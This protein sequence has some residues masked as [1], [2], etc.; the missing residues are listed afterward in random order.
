LAAVA[1]VVIQLSLL[2]GVVVEEAVFSLTVHFQLFQVQY[3][4]IQSVVVGQQMPLV[5]HQRFLL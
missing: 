2:L 3:I 4:H 1:A 5:I